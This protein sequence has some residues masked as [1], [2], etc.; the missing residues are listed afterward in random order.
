MSSTHLRKI[1][2]I[3]GHVNLFNWG[4]KVA[5]NKKNLVR[6]TTLWPFTPKYALV[7]LAVLAEIPFTTLWL[8]KS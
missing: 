8:Y 5:S 4:F 1:S 2:E 6:F 3:S 7:T